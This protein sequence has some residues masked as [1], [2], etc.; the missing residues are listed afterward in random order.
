MGRV[1]MGQGAGWEQ[2]EGE[3]GHGKAVRGQEP[4]DRGRMGLC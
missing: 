2:T 4:G 3:G 1:E